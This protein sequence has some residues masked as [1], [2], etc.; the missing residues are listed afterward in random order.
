MKLINKKNS[1]IIENKLLSNKFLSITNNNFNIN[2]KILKDFFYLDSHNYYP[3]SEE[4]YSFSDIFQWGDKIK[5]QNFYTDNFIKNFNDNKKN[6]KNISDVVVLGSS[7]ADNYYRNM[8]TFLPRIFFLE[9]KKIRIAIHRKSS[10]KFRNFI[11]IMCDKIG[12]DIEFIFLDNGFYSFS[13]SKIMQYLNKDDSIKILNS[14]IIQNKVKNE[15][16]YLSRQNSKFRNIINEG[17]IIE[18]LKK[19]SFKIIDLNSLSIIKQIDLFSKASTIVSP[20]GSSLTNIAFCS[21]GTRI[22]EISPKYNFSYEDN[23]KNRYSYISK[24]L[25]LNY[26]RFEADPIDLVRSD[27]LTDSVILPGKLKESNYYKDMLLKL[28]LLK[29]IIKI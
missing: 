21:P 19:E 4:L 17:D 13:N 20:T 3:I 2:C 16:I 22:I 5:Y 15:K 12:I 6:F 26:Y 18:F 11:S 9:K 29:E 24:K 23:L 1:D 8:F 7:I 27:K 10:N 28:D 25:D 14:L